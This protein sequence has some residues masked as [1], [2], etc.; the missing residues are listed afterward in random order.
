MGQFKIS[1]ISKNGTLHYHIHFKTEPVQCDTNFKNEPAQG[2]TNSRMSQSKM[3]YVS[4]IYKFKMKYSR[5]QI[6]KLLMLMRRCVHRRLVNKWPISRGV[7]GQYFD[8]GG[9]FKAKVKVAI[10]ADSGGPKSDDFSWNL[11]FLNCCIFPVNFIDFSALEVSKS[12]ILEP[13][14]LYLRGLSNF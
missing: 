6:G 12:E 14:P 4:K 13:K 8:S 9:G 3:T 7:K 1:Y 10:E 11:H 5:L 2:D